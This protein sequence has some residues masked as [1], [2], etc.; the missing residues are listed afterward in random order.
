M[1]QQYDK[2]VQKRN[3]LYDDVEYLESMLYYEEG[4]AASLYKDIWRLSEQ[5]PSPQEAQGSAEDELR[6]VGEQLKSMQEEHAAVVQERDSLEM[7]VRRLSEQLEARA[8][9]ADLQEAKLGTEIKQLSEQLWQLGTEL[10]QA[11]WSCDDRAEERLQ[12]KVRHDRDLLDAA[13]SDHAHLVK[14]VAAMLDTQPSRSAAD[15]PGADDHD[16][17]NVRGMQSSSHA[18]LVQEAEARA[19][20]AWGNLTRRMR[21]MCSRLHQNQHTGPEWH[22]PLLVAGLLHRQRLWGGIPAKTAELAVGRRL[23]QQARACPGWKAALQRHPDLQC[24]VDRLLERLERWQPGEHYNWSLK[25]DISHL[26]DGSASKTWELTTQQQMEKLYLTM[27]AQ[28]VHDALQAVEHVIICE[29]PAMQHGS[30]ALQVGKCVALRRWQQCADTS[31][32]ECQ[33]VYACAAAEEETA[34]LDHIA[35]YCTTVLAAPGPATLAGT[36]PEC[37]APE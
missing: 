32:R 16:D 4:H 11:R 26:L 14:A 25:P 21:A 30:A 36:K 15:D 31:I 2:V 6:S 5:L 28:Q 13:L 17:T 20:A 10:Q 19:E 27:H 3:R 33:D 37:N 35:A 22:L 7:S 23:L 29:L 9:Q 12:S 18:T 8:A 34:L 1:G 24:D